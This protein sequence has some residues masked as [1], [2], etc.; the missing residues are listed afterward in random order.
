MRKL[1]DMTNK[2]D[3]GFADWEFIHD[4]QGEVPE[5][6]TPEIISLNTEFLNHI[7]AKYGKIKKQLAEHLKPGKTIHVAIADLENMGDEFKVRGILKAK[8]GHALGFHR[9]VVYDEDRFEDDY[10]GAV[11]SD[12]DGH[13]T[14]SFGKKA[15]SDFGIESE[16]DI[17]FKVF[18]FQAG[19]FVEIGKTMP[20]IYEKTETQEKKTILDFGVVTV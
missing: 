14:L 9:I 5:L 6:I 12:K 7:P 1:I 3:I 8:E 19:R 4:M 20:E 18:F 17:Y 2:S 10:L 13:F 16:P 11:I 15:F